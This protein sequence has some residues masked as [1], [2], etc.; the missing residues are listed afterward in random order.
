VNEAT[1]SIEAVVLTDPSVGDAEAGGDLLN[2][3]GGSPGQVS[4]EG[5]YDKR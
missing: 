2:D 3:T 1:Q 5:T 4:G